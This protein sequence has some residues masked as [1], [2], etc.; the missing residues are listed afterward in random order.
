MGDSMASVANLVPKAPQKD[1]VKFF[2]ADDHLSIH[3]PSQQNTGIVTGKFSEKGPH[4]NQK[5]GELFTAED[6]AVD[7]TI[8]LHDQEFLIVDMDEYSRKWFE[9][10]EAG[11]FNPLVLEKLREGL[12]QQC[13]NVRDIFRKFDTDRDGVLTLNEFR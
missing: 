9:G 10:T 2:L 1:V 5:T 11:P 4:L 6:F 3:E 12:R 7:D 13:V 8:R